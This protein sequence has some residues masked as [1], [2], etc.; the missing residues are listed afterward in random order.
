MSIQTLALKYTEDWI[1]FSVAFYVLLVY[2]CLLFS[3][4]NFQSLER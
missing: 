3:S 4:V 1:L 2:H